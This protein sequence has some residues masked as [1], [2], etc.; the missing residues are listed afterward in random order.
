MEQLKMP[1]SLRYIELLKVLSGRAKQMCEGMPP[2]TEA[3]ETAWKHLSTYFGETDTPLVAGINEL[4]LKYGKKPKNAAERENIFAHIL[5]YFHRV[6]SLEAT[7]GQKRWALEQAILSTMLDEPWVRAWHK[8]TRLMKDRTHPL[9]HGANASDMM[10]CLRKVNIEISKVDQYKHS[11]GSH[12]VGG[13]HVTQPENSFAAAGAPRKKP[14]SQGPRRPRAEEGQQDA[15]QQEIMEKCI[16]C[17]KDRGQEFKH[18]FPS[19]CP[20][21]RLSSDRKKSDEWI[22]KIVLEK[23]ACRNCFSSKHRARDCDAPDRIRCMECK[24]RHHLVFHRSKPKEAKKGLSNVV[25][26]TKEV[27]TN[28]LS[29]ASS[30]KKNTNPF[31][32]G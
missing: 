7:E 2:S 29:K 32:H 13:A 24:E 1:W 4:L 8:L 15:S 14:F 5:K 20:Y 9:G 17:K 27:F 19:G 25:K 28:N 30:G 12:V 31:L 21:V 16:F 11:L 10:E 23:N 6:E 22:R 18:K 26:K 3:Y